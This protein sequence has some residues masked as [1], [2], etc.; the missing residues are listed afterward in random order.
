MI[1]KLTNKLELEELRIRVNETS[2]SWSGEQKADRAYLWSGRVS[3]PTTF[4]T[5]KWHAKKLSRRVGLKM[6]PKR[7]TSSPGNFTTART[8][9]KEVK[10]AEDCILQNMKKGYLKKGNRN[11]LSH[12]VT[13]IALRN[14]V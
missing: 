11:G 12:A 4:T 3:F 8:V 5:E 2:V 9:L 6:R 1:M 10:N 14:I 7:A 13:L